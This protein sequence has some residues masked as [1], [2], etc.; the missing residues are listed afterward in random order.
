MGTVNY[1]VSRQFIVCQSGK[2][3]ITITHVTAILFVQLGMRNTHPIFNYILT[4][5]TI[6][7]IKAPSIHLY[8]MAISVLS[9]ILCSVAKQWEYE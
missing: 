2:C 1:G 5:Y 8:T 3:E 9:W 4:Y 7:N 6:E